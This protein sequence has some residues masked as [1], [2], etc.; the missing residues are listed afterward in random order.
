MQNRLIRPTV[1]RD[2][3]T[4]WPRTVIVMAW[5]NF[6]D[7]IFVGTIATAMMS[8]QLC[9]RDLIMS[10]ISRWWNNSFVTKTSAYTYPFRFNFFF[11]LVESEIIFSKIRERER[12]R[13]SIESISPF[14]EPDLFFRLPS[15]TDSRGVYKKSNPLVRGYH[16]TLRRK[17]TEQFVASVNMEEFSWQTHPSG[18]KWREKTLRTKIS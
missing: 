12:E 7:R 6:A 16:H 3:R 10:M 17:T 14:P 1:G 11:I 15:Q 18:S 2:R 4:R 9:T 8:W 13:E 5:L